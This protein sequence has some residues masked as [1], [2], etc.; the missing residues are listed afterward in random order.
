KQLLDEIDAE[1]LAG[2]VSLDSLLR[3]PVTEAQKTGAPEPKAIA[4]ALTQA[5]TGTETPSAPAQTSTEDGSPKPPSRKDKAAKT[6]T[7]A[8]A[9]TSTASETK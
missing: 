5:Q 1:D 7:S 9:Q 4:D 2:T 3:A 8:P 6:A